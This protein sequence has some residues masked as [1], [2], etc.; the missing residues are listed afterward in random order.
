M[1]IFVLE[2]WCISAVD[3]VELAHEETTWLD[4][5]AHVLRTLVQAS[6]YG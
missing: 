4:K 5:S 2:R 3:L 6:G 1:I